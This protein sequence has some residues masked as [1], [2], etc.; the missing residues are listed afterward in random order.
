MNMK[1]IMKMIIKMIIKQ[2]AQFIHVI[3]KKNI[4]DAD[5]RLEH[6]SVV[7]RK[8]GISYILFCCLSI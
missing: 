3:V 5:K 7:E 1:M 2:Y 6:L 8:I 4:K